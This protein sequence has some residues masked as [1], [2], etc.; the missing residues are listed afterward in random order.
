MIGQ[1]FIHR[2]RHW[3]GMDRAA[4]QLTDLERQC[5]SRH[6]S[7][8]RRMVEIG[9]FEGASTRL[10]VEVAGPDAE[11]F[12]IDPFI[13]GRMGVCWAKAI[14]LDEI[15]R[16]GRAKP[17]VRVALVEKFSHDAAQHLTGTFD[18]IFVDGDHSLE[19]IRR[20]WS[21]WSGRVQPGGVIALHDTRVPPHN[22]G[23]AAL[24]SCQFFESTIR[25]DE[26]FTL[27]EQ[28]DSLS[29]LQRR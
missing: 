19:G 8:R 14:A 23:V 16:A 9:V 12:G 1:T 11:I 17:G 18:F 28:A 21:D 10:L 22:P 29:V 26:R 7:G 4:S 5:L 27:V 25:F 24:G 20:D 15:R 13:P 6:A 2:T 3:L